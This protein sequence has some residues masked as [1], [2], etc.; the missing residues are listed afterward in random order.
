MT[1]TKALTTLLASILAVAAVAGAVVAPKRVY[2][3]DSA[4]SLVLDG[5]L[6]DAA[7]EN[8][9]DDEDWVVKATDYTVES[10]IY[11]LQ[12]SVF[13]GKKGT[14][15]TTAFLRTVAKDIITGLSGKGSKVELVS[16]NEEKVDEKAAIRQTHKVTDA[17]GTVVVKSTL[18]G[19]G[20]NV[21]LVMGV[22]FPD[23]KGSVEGIDK[24][25][26]SVRY[27]SGLKS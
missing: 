3:G 16:N 20:Q 9:T 22:C 24:I 8:V 18:I 21:Y 13:E 17:D 26:R 19:D 4:L 12:V 15:A 10:D 2:V 23:V 14:Q 1:T 5:S 25:M 6:G 7:V 11:V 27:K